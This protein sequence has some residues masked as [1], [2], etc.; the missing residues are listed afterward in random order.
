MI[1]TVTSIL[2][3]LPWWAWAVIAVVVISVGAQN[4]RVGRAI[5]LSI[6]YG[7]IGVGLYGIWSSGILQGAVGSFAQH[8]ARIERENARI[9]QIRLEGQEAYFRFVCPDYF[10]LGW[11]SRQVSTLRWCNDYRDRM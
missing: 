10:E 7:L 4:D 11:V 1:D 3:N 8:A 9:D 5:V 6:A 2:G